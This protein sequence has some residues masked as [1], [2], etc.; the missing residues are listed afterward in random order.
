MGRLVPW[1]AMIDKVLI[2]P[3][4]MSTDTGAHCKDKNGRALLITITDQMALRTK[5]CTQKISR[6]DA[7]LLKFQSSGM[8]AWAQ[9]ATY[10]VQWW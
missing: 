3:V 10:E 1:L 2:P 6:M 7:I 8:R 5:Y 4:Q 9:D